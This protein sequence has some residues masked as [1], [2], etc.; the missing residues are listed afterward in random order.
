MAKHTEK[1]IEWTVDGKTFEGHAVWSGNGPKPV[2]LVCHAWGGQ[3]DFE[4]QRAAQ[5]ADLGYVGFAADVYGKGVTADAVDDCQALMTPL[6]EN[7][8]Q[9]LERLRASLEAARKLDA[10]DADR[11]AAIGFCFGGLC[12]LDMA[13]AGLDLRGVVSFHGLLSPRPK[14]TTPIKPRVLI[15]HGY[16]DPMAS[17]DAL[18]GFG[19]EMTEAGAD[20]QA[21][22][23]GGTKHA[24]TNP[25]ANDHDL[26][27]V[28]DADADRRSRQGMERFL[29]EI[30]GG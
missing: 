24:F 4:R 18:L 21:H 14:A 8:D 7:R 17:P 29:A 27:T 30:V 16:D 19:A 26:G 15:H 25:N 9:L 13:R 22:V 10:A 23:Y 2:V 5:L 6:M 3:K 12:V 1:K 28:Y 11:A 20:W